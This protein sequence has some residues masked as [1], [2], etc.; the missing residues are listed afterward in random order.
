MQTKCNV[1]IIKTVGTV[2]S[3]AIKDYDESQLFKKCGFKKP[4]NF[5]MVFGGNA[6]ID[7]IKYVI[8]IYGKTI[9]RHNTENKYDFPP[10]NDNTLF[11]GNCLVVACVNNTPINL[12]ILLW[13]KIYDTMF[14]GFESIESSSNDEDDID[15]LEN[16]PTHK[17]TK[18]GYLKDGFVTDTIEQIDQNEQTSESSDN[19]QYETDELSEEQYNYSD[20]D[21]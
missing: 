11:F 14:G 17:L 1:I 16:M 2:T 5:K 19:T 13:N 4:D 6:I 9:G 3:L 15:E 18:D 8:N 21:A 20:N 10:P 12:T 7:D